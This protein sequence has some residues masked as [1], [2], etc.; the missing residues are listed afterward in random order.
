MD[1]NPANPAWHEYD[2]FETATLADVQNCL[3]AGFDVNSCPSISLSPL[4]NAVG[5]TPNPKIIRALL[6]AGAR[7]PGYALYLAIR[8]DS[9]ER[10][11]L[12]MLIEAGAGVNATD[13]DEKSRNP[14]QIAVG[15]GKVELVAMLM[16]AG[17]DPLPEDWGSGDTAFEWSRRKPEVLQ[18]M[19]V[20]G[21]DLDWRDEVTFCNLL[22][23]AVQNYHRPDTA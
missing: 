21:L 5:D 11:I 18:A 8:R 23:R 19:I 17:A 15:E 3:R 6:D 9:H 4:E 20:N 13:P 22:H 2:W 10:E 16:Q 14:L 7:I 12:Q 1:E